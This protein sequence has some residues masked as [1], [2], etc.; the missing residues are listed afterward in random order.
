MWWWIQV[1]T[2]VVPC[3]NVMLFPLRR[4]ATS[5]S[6]CAAHN[7]A[8]LCHYEQIDCRRWTR[9]RN[10]LMTPIPAQP[11]STTT[12]SPATR[13]GASALVVQANFLCKAKAVL[14]QAQIAYHAIHRSIVR[15][16]NFTTTTNKGREAF[17]LR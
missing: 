6:F 14:I 5:H 11:D 7:H 13:R 4:K 10:A 12:T 16:R 15:F 2:I 17:L 3:L 9:S 8:R 1:G